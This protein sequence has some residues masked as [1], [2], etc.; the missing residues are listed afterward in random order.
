[1]TGIPDFGFHIAQADVSHVGCKWLDVPYAGRSP[2]QR[3][4]I[5]LPNAGSGPYPV[6]IFIHGGGF[7]LGH[8]RDPHIPGLLEVRECGYALV[9]LDYRLSGEAVFPAGVQD[10]KAAVRWLRAR[11]GE[12][13]LDTERVVAWGT[14]SGGN[15]AALL[16]VSEGEPLFDDPSLGNEGVSSGIRAAVDWFGPTDFL[17]MDEQLEASGFG[18]GGHDRADSAESRYLGA[19]ITEAPDKVRLANPMTYINPRM[20]PILIQHGT[21]D[22]IV[23][24]QQ[25]VE[26]ARTVEERLG[27]GVAEIDLL[28]GAGHEDETF[29]TPENM[30]RVLDFVERHL[31]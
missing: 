14:S 29:R 30:A 31:R 10:T 6:I 20:A 8:K 7:A 15:F 26:L 2:A 17:A 1:M 16:A 23:P 21:A 25:S 28:E 9:S 22:R 5:Y 3:L 11:G 4:D 27:P 12:Y 13:S 24:V 19:P 18:P